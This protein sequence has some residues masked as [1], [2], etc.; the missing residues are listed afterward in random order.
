MDDFKKI[1][2]SI[3]TPQ[4]F[5]ISDEEINNQAKTINENNYFAKELIMKGSWLTSCYELKHTC[6]DENDSEYE[7]LFDDNNILCNCESVIITKMKRDR[8]GKLIKENIPVKLNEGE[9]F[10]E[11]T[12]LR[13]IRDYYHA[14]LSEKELAK[15][16]YETDDGWGYNEKAQKALEDKTELKRHEIMGDCVFLE[17]IEPVGIIGNVAFYEIFIGS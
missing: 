9:K 12:I 5:G 8:Y 17:I 2:M 4:A 14:P 15:I 10:T 3:H 16:A 11:L 7:M 13:T 6:I 1:M